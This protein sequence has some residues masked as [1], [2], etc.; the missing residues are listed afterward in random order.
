MALTLALAISSAWLLL[1]TSQ[2]PD[3]AAQN[4]H[5]PTLYITS[6]QW[7]VLDERGQL[8]QRLR[9]ERMEQWA[10]ED[11]I[12]LLQPRLFARGADGSSWQ[13]SAHQGRFHEMSRPATLQGDVVVRKTRLAD[14]GEL[15]L[16]TDLLLISTSGDHIE[17]DLP[18][19]LRTGHWKFTAD[20][21]QAH[22]NP[23]KIKLAGRVRGVH[24]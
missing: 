20:S 11:D 18:V 23:D 3:S 8:K 13:A 12:R 6:P 21:L 15:T 10:G 14:D 4:A 16:K 1:A 9:A 7:D 24:D 22:F 19:V 2:A 5:E 17:T